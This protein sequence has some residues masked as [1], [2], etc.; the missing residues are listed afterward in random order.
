MAHCERLD[1]NLV[2]RRNVGELKIDRTRPKRET[3]TEEQLYKFWQ[4]S[5]EREKKKKEQEEEKKKGTQ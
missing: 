1:G 5:E 4:L 2:G 3:D